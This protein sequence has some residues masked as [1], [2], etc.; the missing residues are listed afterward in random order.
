MIVN[1]ET[2]FS[3]V[4]GMLALGLMAGVGVA[5]LKISDMTSQDRNRSSS[6]SEI[7][8]LVL[9]IK[10]LLENPVS[11]RNSFNG[12][13]ATSASPTVIRDA[14]N[15][16]FFTVGT[17]YNGI[18]LNSMAILPPST[19]TGTF[20][21]PGREGFI[22]L[23]LILTRPAASKGNR[24]VTKRITIWAET[25]AS[26]TIINCGGIGT[27]ASNLWAR[28]YL[29]ANDIYYQGGM[30]A[31]GATLSGASAILSTQGNIRVTT[32]VGDYLDIGGDSTADSGFIL[33]SAKPLTFS[34]SA[35]GRDS[36]ILSYSMR[37]THSLSASQPS[38]G[39]PCNSA[40]GGHIRFESSAGT[41][42][43]CNSHTSVWTTFKDQ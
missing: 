15:Q 8:S 13:N 12:L 41:L 10:T 30:V 7:R 16:P 1:K 4:E 25:N 27:T 2:G 31:A 18:I 19:N 32:P 28:S 17:T 37:L 40:N 39:I 42:Q 29:N 26:N 6:N 38:V 23:N 20:I 3:L 24:S 21:S 11:C 36:T 14:L 43:W 33:G 34:N 9:Q 5:A 22:P 35:T